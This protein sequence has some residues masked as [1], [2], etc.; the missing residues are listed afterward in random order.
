MVKMILFMIMMRVILMMM[1]MI[2]VLI[3][4]RMIMPSLSSGGAGSPG[5]GQFVFSLLPHSI[6]V[7]TIEVSLV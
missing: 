2:L 5:G 6:W 3:T 1:L 7:N 4:M